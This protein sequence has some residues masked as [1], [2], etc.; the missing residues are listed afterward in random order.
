[1]VNFGGQTVLP[2]TRQ[3]IFYRK[4]IVGKYPN[5]ENLNAKF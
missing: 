1:M 4:K 2:D 3:V 5:A